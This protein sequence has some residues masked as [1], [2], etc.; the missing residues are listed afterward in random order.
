M[1]H[2]IEFKDNK[3]S[4]IENGKN[5]LAW[6]KLGTVYDRPLSAVE[7]LEGCR[8]NY[9]V[10]FRNIA[11]LTKEQEECIRNGQPVKIDVSQLVEGYRSVTREDEQRSLSIVKSRYE[12]LQN[13]NAFE[14]V[15]F[16][17]TG[18][19]GKKASID[20]AG[21]L[22]N[23]RK[24]FITAKFDDDV[25]IPGSNNDIINMYLVFTNSFDGESPVCCMTTP[26]R[27]VCNNT[28][29]AAFSHN[30]GRVSFRH[31]SHIRTHLS[32]KEENIRHALSCLNVMDSYKKELIH[33]VELLGNMKLTTQEVENTIKFALCS[34][35]QRKMLVKDNFNIDNND[36]YST[37]YKNRVKMFLDATNN[38]VGQ[39][40]INKNT[41]LWVVNGVT[42]ALQ[43]VVSFKNEEAKFKSLTSS[44]G[45]KILNDTVSSLIAACA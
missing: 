14:F 8:A 19:L 12:I 26:I 44:T 13:K 43:N 9:D 7:A 38:G 3:Y 23:G 28:L 15:D 18:E 39:N 2:E 4:Y 6:H 35:D 31:T 20:A 45:Q 30:S 24:V 17:T 36:N 22:Y 25:K 29:N 11:N 5:G 34:E 37:K 1:A 27:V 16:L 10:G 40:T 41:G 33:N 42:T 32:L 21:V